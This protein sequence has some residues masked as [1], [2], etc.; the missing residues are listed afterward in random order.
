M[1]AGGVF[2]LRQR[3][4]KLSHFDSRYNG[5]NRARWR[6]RLVHPWHS[7]PVPRLAALRH[8]HEQEGWRGRR[9]GFWR[10]VLVALVAG[11]A[12]VKAAGVYGRLVA[13]PVGQRGEATASRRPRGDARPADRCPDA[14]CCRPRPGSR[15]S[16]RRLRRRRG[17]GGPVPRSLRSKGSAG[18]GQ[19][20]W[21]S[22]SGKPVLWPPCKPNVARW[23]PR[24]GK[25][26]RKRLRLGTSRRSLVLRI[27]RWQPGA[28]SHAM[29]PVK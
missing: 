22:E 23:Q 1:F 16:T 5:C 6:R 8:R 7:G 4:C 18:R 28:H 17:T 26:R 13:A 21:M 9:I 19:G 24:V 25:S 14:R 11:L 27:K 10:L 3:V 20:S 12:V 29:V 2:L 15:K